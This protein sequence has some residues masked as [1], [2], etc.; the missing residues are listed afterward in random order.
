MQ[1]LSTQSVNSISTHSKLDPT[2]LKDSQLTTNRLFTNAQ[3]QQPTLS[4]HTEQHHLLFSLPARDVCRGVYCHALKAANFGSGTRR[5]AVGE[6][7]PSRGYANQTRRQHKLRPQTLT[8]VQLPTNAQLPTNGSSSTQPIS[9]HTRS[10]LYQ[11]PQP[12]S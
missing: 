6:S 2:L 7:R 8:N 9:D 12:D 11:R 1:R 3:N 4:R 5:D 10:M